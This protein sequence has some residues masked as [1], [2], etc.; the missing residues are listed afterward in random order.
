MNIGKNTRIY[1]MRLS[2]K[3]FLKQRCPELFSDTIAIN[4]PLLDRLQLEYH[5]STLSSRSQEIDFEH[6]AKAICEVEICPN[7]LPHTGPTGG[8]DSKVD[9]ETYP[10]SDVTSL[11]WFVGTGNKSASERWGFAFSIQKQ[12]LQK[13]KNDVE[14]ICNTGRNYKVVYFVSSQS[15]SDK[16]RS[17]IEEELSSKYGIDVRVLDRNWILDKVFRNKHEDIAIEK[18][19]IACD[20]REKL[21]KGPLDLQRDN[22]L[23]ALDK[24]IEIAISKDQISHNTVDAALESATLAR[25]LE[26]PR[27]EV[28]GRF[29]RAERLADKYG[30]EYQK[31][32]I[33]Y[34]RAR[35]NFWWYEDFVTYKNLYVRT[36][37]IAFGMQ[38]IN[39]NVLSQLASLWVNIS[40]LYREKRQL[41][42]KKYFDRHSLSLKN[43]L[44]TISKEEGK[45][46]AS[47]YA[48][49]IIIE[50]E[51]L[52]RLHAGETQ[53]QTLIDLKEVIEQSRGLIGFPFRVT[54]QIITELSDIFDNYPEY[55]ELFEMLLKVIE[56]RDGDLASAQLQLD[57]GNKLLSK[58]RPYEAIKV[59]GQAVNKLF[60]HESEKEEIQALCLLGIAYN[61]VGLLWAGR[62]S[63]LSAA[64]L[65]TN[66]YHNYHKINAA[67]AR[68]YNLLRWIELRLGRLPQALE[69]HQLYLTMMGA[70]ESDGI[71]YEEPSLK[72]NI[73]FDYDLG[74]LI[75]RSDINTLKLLE[76]LPGVLDKLGL[77]CSKISLLYSLGYENE[78]PKSFV[79]DASLDEIFSK[80]ASIDTG[81]HFSPN[82]KLNEESIIQIKSNVLGCQIIVNIENNDTCLGFAESLLAAIESF[83]STTILKNAIS[84][85]PLLEVNI[86]AISETTHNLEALVIY[87]INDSEDKP[88]FLIHCKNFSLYKMAKLVQDSLKDTIC[89]ILIEM[90]KRIIVF[91]DIQK[92]INELIN[93][94]KAMERALNLTSSFIVLG[95]VLGYNPKT[96]ISD[97]T[98]G[99]DL[100][101]YPYKRTDPLVFNQ[102]SKN[103]FNSPSAI[104]EEVPLSKARHTDMQNVSVIKIN[105]WDEAQWR[106]VCYIS[107]RN[108][109]TPPILGIMFDNIDAGNKIFEAWRN[110]FGKRDSNEEIRVTFIEGIDKDNVSHYAVGIGSNIQP[111]QEGVTS[112]KF[113]VTIGRRHT[114]TSVFSDNLKYFRQAYKKA[115]CYLLIP[116]YI[117]PDGIVQPNPRLGIIKRKANFRQ[118]WEIGPHDLDCTFVSLEDNPI[119]PE[120]IT[121]PPI[122][123]LM[124]VIKRDKYLC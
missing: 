22:D 68:C 66:D 28:D 78:V 52:E 101:P 114:M 14:K 90:T 18:L 6:F 111:S 3:G 102:T 88:I 75:V 31:F 25:E 57:R 55:T 44:K 48:K 83:F 38:Y 61:Y 2:P 39:V 93:V 37:E 59:L 81:Q 107:P 51:L 54:A 7:L 84:K 123:E 8:G 63:L 105:H 62:G 17:I 5:L 13:I 98:K 124:K 56:E 122:N 27:I 21:R 26:K 12:W 30:S 73:G 115:G 4:E 42:D 29:D 94:E 41:F 104:Q 9:S 76:Q 72:N 34:Q 1:Q 11:N 117:S 119:V 110:R 80:Y 86:D 50:I 43:K 53:T 70:L 120:G 60:T 97:W 77:E 69:W 100:S 112:S 87:E 106:G 109:N 16:R 121:N 95:N 108:G 92:D 99:D 45:P 15:V 36:E 82:L 103:D 71:I 58:D 113:F 47:L 10:V 49:N 116:C 23:L 67:Q 89:K 118:E 35:T 32:H 91:K 46:S 79:G 64:S 65:A 20:N 74:I 24:E 33:A 19:R 40:T 85:E 96:K